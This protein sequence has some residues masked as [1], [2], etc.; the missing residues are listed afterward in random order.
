MLVDLAPL[1]EPGKSMAEWVAGAIGF[2]FDPRKSHKVKK[3]KTET[4]ELAEQRRQSDEGLRKT[5]D[6]RTLAELSVVPGR[7]GQD[8]L[9][10]PARLPGSFGSGRRR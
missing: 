1:G 5:R 4:A 10:S 6:P 9:D 2:K 8:L 3:S 7:S